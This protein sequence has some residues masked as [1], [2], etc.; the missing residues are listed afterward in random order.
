MKTRHLLEYSLLRFFMMIMISLPVTVVLAL[1]QILGKVIW[2]LVPI[3]LS[4]VLKN[5]QTVFPDMP[6]K[7]RMVLARKTYFSIAHDFFFSMV[8]TRKK[9]SKQISEANVTGLDDLKEALSKGKGVI[10]T[11]IHLGCFQPFFALL[12]I[13]DL[14]VTMIYQR[15]ENPYSDKF[16]IRQRERFGTSLEH[17]PKDA[18][19]AEYQRILGKNR[20]LVVLVDQFF[21]SGTN[22]SFFGKETLLAKGPAVLHQR[23]GAPI[24]YSVC[25]FEDGC[26]HIDFREIKLPVT[27]GSE[28][29]EESI[30]QIMKKVVSEYEP[31]I[32]EHPEE[33][34]NLFHKTWKLSGY[35][36]KI[37]R[38]W[39]DIF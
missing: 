5:L 11:S 23:T 22:V 19:M 15:Q 26:F 32:R 28:I 8:M 17:V 25:Y 9:I 7:E 4:V 34:F 20:T 21:S 31:F 24:F 3:R 38:S 13:Q 2:L 10:L 36:D 33:W 18:G 1:S 27:I 35:P 39:R 37:S 14:P 29:D 6:A 12:N 16:F 30:N